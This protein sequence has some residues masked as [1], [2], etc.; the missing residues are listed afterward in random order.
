MA[1][2]NFQDNVKLDSLTR[3]VNE[4]PAIVI[5]TDPGFKSVI[6]KNDLGEL[7]VVA[8]P[9]TNR[10]ITIPDA[11]GT[12]ILSGDAIQGLGVSTL[13]NTA[14]NT[15]TTIGTVVLAGIGNVTL[16]QS[17]A[18]GSQATISISVQNQ[19]MTGYTFPDNFQ[20][21]NFTISDATLSLQKVVI[22]LNISATRVQLLMDLTGASNS[23]GALT[24]SMGVYTLSGSTASLSTS[25]SRNLTWTSGSA[26]TVSSI[27]GGVSGT[28]YRTLAFNVTLTPGD[29]L[30]GIHLKTTNNGTW[31]IFGAN[32]ASIVGA[33][34][35]NETNYF[36][37]GTSVSSF[38]TAFPA[39]IN[40]TDTN[41]ARTG[42]AALRQPGMI[43]IGT[44]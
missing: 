29:Y 4:G 19:R 8:N 35:A 20:V 28:R 44:F 34:D 18:V 3:L 40:V 31:R 43:M 33:V 10:T 13:G 22:G 17:T 11:S 9:T 15:G 42:A 36:L 16:S 7:H 26:T 32:A 5:G 39:S 30:V 37:N 41:Y 14:G 27:Y 23:S 6:L 2:D 38:T 12:L 24:I 21:T 25:A 1:G